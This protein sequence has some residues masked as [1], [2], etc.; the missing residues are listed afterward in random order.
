MKR[1]EE[2]EKKK[3]SEKE[4]PKVLGGQTAAAPQASKYKMEQPRKRTNN[5]SNSG[6]SIDMIKDT[7]PCFSTA[8]HGKGTVKIDAS[9][10]KGRTWCKSG[11]S[12]D[13][14]S[15]FMFPATFILFAVLYWL[16]FNMAVK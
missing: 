16:I 13:Y 2:E 6:F 4:R 7:L 10:R 9:E 12:I 11:Y 8:K 15:R 3:K 1:K 14:A 5:M